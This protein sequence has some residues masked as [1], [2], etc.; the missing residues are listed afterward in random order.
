ML[1]CSIVGQPK[2]TTEDSALSYFFC[3]GADW[4][5]NNAVAVLRGL[6]Y[7]LAD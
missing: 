5:I 6:I 3:Q 4:R 7:L 2:S 1:F